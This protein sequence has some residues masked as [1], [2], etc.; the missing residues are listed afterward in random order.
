MNN[1]EA[2]KIIG[3]HL[4]KIVSDVG[5]Y[6]YDMELIKEGSNLVLRIYVDKENGINI[7]ECEKVSRSLMEILDVEDPID[8]A[9]TLEV[10]SPGIDRKLRRP[11]HFSMNIGSEVELKTYKP[12]N[13][14]KKFTGELISYEDGVITI[15]VNNENIKFDEVD[16]ALCKLT[17]NF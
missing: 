9:Y 13:N 4:E 12:F 15:E 5:V 2:L 3:G 7:E 10:S 14:Q 11:E 1:K 8:V 6:L 16:V 17:I